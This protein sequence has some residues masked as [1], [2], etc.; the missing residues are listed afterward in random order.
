MKSQME[1]RAEL[2]AA[3][4]ERAYAELAASVTPRGKIPPAGLDDNEQI[5]KA[6]NACLRYI[7]VE[8]CEV[9]G[10]INNLDERIDWLC[11]PSGTMHRRVRLSKGWHKEAFGAMLGRLDTGE[12]EGCSGL[13]PVGEGAGYAGGIVSAAVDGISAARKAIEKSTLL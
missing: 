11:R 2:N 5:D 4:T 7:G 9:P 3:K 1:E 10:S 8:P 12:A 13:F 6:V